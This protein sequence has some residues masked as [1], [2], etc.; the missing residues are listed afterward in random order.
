M[1]DDKTLLELLQLPH[2]KWTPETLQRIREHYK[3][4]KL[5]VIMTS[6]HAKE[7]MDNY[8]VDLTKTDWIE[9]HDGQPASSSDSVSIQFDEN[10]KSTPLFSGGFANFDPTALSTMPT[11]GFSGNEG[12]QQEYRVAKKYEPKKNQPWYRRHAKRR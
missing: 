3:P 12:I 10:G 11:F 5:K 6:A 2:N 7:Y 1:D 8:G 9:V 4:R